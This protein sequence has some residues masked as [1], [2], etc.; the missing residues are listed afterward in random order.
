MNAK[1]YLSIQSFLD[2]PSEESPYAK[3]NKK[4]KGYG[5]AALSMLAPLPSQ[6]AGG[7]Y[8]L[9]SFLMGQG[10]DKA[11][12]DVAKVQEWNFGF[13]AYKPTTEEGQQ[14][15]ESLANMFAYP[16][17]KAGDVGAWVGKKL[18]NEELGRLTAK[19][20]VDVA[21][22]WLP[23]HGIVKV[24]IKA[25]E[26][27]NALRKK[28][29]TPSSDMGARVDA[30]KA[31]VS[32]EQ[33]LNESPA[34]QQMTDQLTEGWTSPYRP[35][36]PTEVKSKG[37]ME[38]V[39]QTLKATGDQQRAAAAQE[40][41]NL[42]QQALEQ[43]VARQTSLDQNAAQRARQENAPTGYEQWRE[44]QQQAAEQRTPGDNTP[45]NMES[46]YPVDV[47]Q[48]PQVLQD[49]PYQ[50]ENTVPYDQPM[51]DQSLPVEVRDALG[52]DATPDPF[53]RYSPQQAANRILREGEHPP[54]NK[55]NDP[56]INKFGQGGKLHLGS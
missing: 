41:L 44:G 5:E 30:L 13:G 16:G 26:G 52:E 48:F 29:P 47:N 8:G 56:R 54:I 9:N 36:I 28:A 4:L 14:S 23:L 51:L 38:Q 53:N 55:V 24:P 18:G 32:A 25:A 6:I 46:P 40:A 35:D 31:K 49:A 43:E 1:E 22:N 50:P 3:T 15:A 11:A 27:I 12:E 7:L 20:P 34:L 19:L 45:M 10:L 2:E 42:R 17:E 21:M 33:F 37:V 39:A